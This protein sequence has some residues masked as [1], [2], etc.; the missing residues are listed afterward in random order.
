MMAV[1]DVAERLKISGKLVRS[2]INRG[3]LQCHRIGSLI[4]V[5]ESQLTRY[6]DSVNGKGQGQS[7]P[8]PQLSPR[9]DMESI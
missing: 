2:L 5:S 7:V 1:K 3:E 6:L 8:A 9:L 4:R